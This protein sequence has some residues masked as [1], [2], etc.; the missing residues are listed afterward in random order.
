MTI[1]RAQCG[2]RCLSLGRWCRSAVAQ[3]SWSG[4]CCG[5]ASSLSERASAETAPKVK[6]LLVRGGC[7]D[8]ISMSVFRIHAYGSPQVPPGQKWTHP[9]LIWEPHM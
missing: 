5:R 4:L 1:Q 7:G 2:R 3:Q 6:S 8:V 9:V